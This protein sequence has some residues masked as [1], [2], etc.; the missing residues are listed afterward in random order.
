M[1]RSIAIAL[2]LAV[3][4]PALAQPPPEPAPPSSPPPFTAPSTRA[5]A[6]NVPAVPAKPPRDQ[7][8][9]RC[10][11]GSLGAGARRADLCAHHGGVAEWLR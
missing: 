9:A 5:P 3:T 10:K 11:D 4:A 7:V 8:T 1:L 2:A 6:T